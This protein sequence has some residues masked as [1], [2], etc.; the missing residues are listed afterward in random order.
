[1]TGFARVAC[2]L[3]DSLEE[4][5][6]DQCGVDKVKPVPTGLDR[7]YISRCQQVIE[8]RSLAYENQIHTDAF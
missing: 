7:H 6:E 2:A 1:M 4:Y 3:R 8:R 5:L